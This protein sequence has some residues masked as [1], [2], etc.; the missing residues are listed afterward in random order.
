MNLL[1]TLILTLGFL[2][3]TPDGPDDEAKA[4]RGT[5]ALTNA[6]IVT[7]T[8]GVIEN[9]T[10]VIQDDKIIALGPNV[11]V[12][13]DAE[14]IDCSGLEIY[15]GLIDSGTQTGLIEVGSLAE[16]QDARELGD[17]TPQMK[18]LTAVNPNSVV[19]P[20]TRVNGITT[21][22]TQPS[23]GLLPGTAALINL[24]GYTPEQ[25][26]VGDFEAITMQYPVT[27]RRGRWDRRSDE[28]IKKDAEKAL[29]KLNDAWDQATLFAQIDSAYTANPETGRRPEYVPAM[30][31]LLPVLRGERPLIITVNAAADIVS[32]IEWVEE[33]G[34]D[35]VIFSGLAEGWR[36]ADQIAEAGIPALVGPILSVPTRESDRYDKAYANASLLHEAGVKVA[37]RTG[38]TE[39]VR[40]LP[41]HAGFAAAYGL[42][43]EQALRAV[44][45]VPAEIFG[46][47]DLIGSLEVGKQANLFVTN[48]D[49]FETR[50]QVQHLFI[51]GYKIPLESRH[52]RLYHEFLDRE[53]GLMR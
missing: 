33:R 12:P 2:L 39:N 43:K 41:Y 14:V 46:V 30:T 40:N 47:S 18:A 16:T 10:L 3:G 4:R 32:A 26:H 1:L 24:H 31:A 21:V 44:T 35:N 27:G 19:I 34:M 28:Q 42:G 5:F 50:T 7:V 37:I 38:E 8:N 11:D 52:T 29:K 36:V 25:M 15:P 49:P 51:D 45:I 13:A 22:I 17:L 9:G 53:P 6:R 48:G 20:V 23:G